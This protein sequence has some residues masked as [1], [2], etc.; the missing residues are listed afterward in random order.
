MGQ[1]DN[2]RKEEE[3]FEA[4]RKKVK[5]EE[6]NDDLKEPIKKKDE[7]IFQYEVRRLEHYIRTV[8]RLRIKCLS[9]LLEKGSGEEEEGNTNQ[10]T[11]F[12]KAAALALRLQRIP[13]LLVT[14]NG[15]HRGKSSGAAGAY[16]SYGTPG[17]QARP[18]FIRGDAKVSLRY[19]NTLQ[20]WIFRSGDSHE[21][22]NKKG[23]ILAASKPEDKGAKAAGDPAALSCSIYP[24]FSR[25]PLKIWS[26]SAKTGWKGDRVPSFAGD[27]LAFLHMKKKESSSSNYCSDLVSKT[28][29]SLQRARDPKQFIHLKPQYLRGRQVLGVP[30]RKK[31]RKKKWLW[32]SRNW[33]IVNTKKLG[34]P[35]GPLYLR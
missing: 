25:L 32:A 9:F 19:D 35:H 18:K 15:N 20:A 12:Q 27:I 16:W 33:N 13:D 8:R 17:P 6:E 7:R 31:H 30:K 11:R 14:E 10:E 3:E 23:L 28:R 21:W 26:L 2:L 34:T 1:L 5:G 24:S 29:F 22:K 4:K